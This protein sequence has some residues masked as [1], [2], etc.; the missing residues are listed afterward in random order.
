[1]RS[2]I[3]SRIRVGCLR[4]YLKP[5]ATGGDGFDSEPNT[6][7]NEEKGRVLDCRF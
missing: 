1:M 6:S 7:Q 4:P 3:E 2:K 5:E